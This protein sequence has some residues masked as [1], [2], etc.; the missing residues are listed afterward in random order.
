MT[1]LAIIDGIESLAGGEGPWIQGVRYIAPGV[2]I[3][4][5]NPVSTDAV[6]TAVMGFDPRTRRGAPPFENCDNTMLLAEELGIGTT[7]LE[8]IDVRG[9]S[10]QE[11]VFRF[12]T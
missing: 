8:Q 10:I 12:S 9:A 2:L 3:A 1:R 11:S 4:G 7:D 5:L 6:A